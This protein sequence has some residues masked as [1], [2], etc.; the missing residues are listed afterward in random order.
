MNRSV[1][2]PILISAI[3]GAAVWALS[4]AMTGKLEP[5]DADGIYYLVSLG[6]AGFISACIAP[7]PLW[8]L[9]VG[10]ILGQVLYGLIF[11]PLGPLAVIGLAFLTVW[12]LVFL[13]AAFLGS[14]VR[15]VVAGRR[16]AA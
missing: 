11:L 12:S 10:A 3:F 7:K 1:I 9:Y 2:Y 6:L 16:S 8:A 5:W 13:L 4:P 15:A 14:R